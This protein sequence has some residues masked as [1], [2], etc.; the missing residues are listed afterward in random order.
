[1][2]QTDIKEKV[3]EIIDS[4]D[5]FSAMQILK[6]TDFGK[7]LS[8]IP[9]IPH[10]VPKLL[11]VA[12]AEL[13]N[14]LAQ[15]VI[16]E[17]I[18]EF[19]RIGTPFEEALTN[20]YLFQGR[21][22]KNEQRE[23]LLSAIRKNTETIAGK[24]IGEWIALYDK[25]YNPNERAEDDILPFVAKYTKNTS[26]SEGQIAI[27][28]D[29]LFAYDNSL[30]TLLIDVFDI[31]K[32]ARMIEQGLPKFTA[33]QEKQSIIPQT[34]PVSPPNK[35]SLPKTP[36]ETE[37]PKT[38][39]SLPLKEAIAKY[40]KVADACITKRDI[41]FQESNGP[42]PPTVR[43]WIT[44]YRQE[45]GPNFHEPFERSQF[46]FHN[47]NA[48]LLNQEERN[49]LSE[50]L[51]SLDEESEL[52]IISETQTIDLEKLFS[53]V[54]PSLIS[55]S[56][57]IP[58]KKGL[59]IKKLSPKTKDELSASKNRNS[60]NETQKKT[61]K[62]ESV[63][64]KE[65]IEEKKDAWKEEKKVIP[66][67]NISSLP[68]MASSNP[69]T[70][71]PSKNASFDIQTSVG[72]QTSQQSS[73]SKKSFFEKASSFLPSF[74]KKEDASLEQKTEKTTSISDVSPRSPLP[75]HIS[76]TGTLSRPT[77]EK[78]GNIAANLSFSS[79]Q[80]FSGEKTQNAPNEKVKDEL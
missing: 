26:T 50:V 30:A 55:S 19:Y 24:T 25:E 74:L 47:K 14:S 69:K 49:A 21:V 64:S 54:S 42:V 32:A 22:F 20:R 63:F 17:H 13:P 68:K 43:N 40:P 7:S 9:E 16:S 67:P 62:I 73:I 65:P 11:A 52:P 41:T 56:P 35:I 51:R 23:I 53:S 78:R 59:E 58:P 34:Y 29:I 48:I 31:D 1:M 70:F 3:R 39:L 18:L 57:K 72:A 61:E 60:L 10:T 27:L 12:F 76:N 36:F 75:P 71:F 38:I 44:A 37:V 33:P 66:T 46:L 77:P 8:E 45:M 4:Y 28:K 5:S 15:K 79:P 6:E 2:P 80:R